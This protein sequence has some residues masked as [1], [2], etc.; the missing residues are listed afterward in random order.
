IGDAR[1]EAGRISLADWFAGRRYSVAGQ[2]LPAGL[3][4]LE[5][6]GEWIS[7]QNQL[8]RIDGRWNRHYAT[9]AFPIKANRLLPAVNVEHED[10]RQHIMGGDSLGFESFRFTRISPNIAWRSD[11]LE[12]SADLTFRTDEQWMDGALEHA[13]D[14]WTASSGIDYAGTR[15]SVDARVGLRRREF[16]E[17]FRKREGR[18]D[19][20]TLVVRSG[21]RWRPRR[22][23]I[24]VLASYEANS[25]R[26]PLLQEIFVRTGPE[27]GQF[28][29][30]DLN[31]DEVIQL[32]E[33]IPERTPNEGVYGRTYLPTDS[34]IS[35]VSVRARSELRVDGD[36]LWRDA[37]GWRRLLAH[38][39]TRSTF[40]VHESTRDDDLAR[41]YLLD[42]S[43]FR[44]PETTITGRARM[45]QSVSLWPRSRIF[46]I[47]AD[48]SRV[49]SLNNR[50]MGEEAQSFAVS[51][52][53]ARWKPASPVSLLLRVAKERSRQLSQQ[54]ETRRFDISSRRLEPEVV[55]RLGRQ[56][57][58][59]APTAFA[60]KNDSSTDQRAVIVRLPLEV[61]YEVPRRL[62]W[63]SRFEV[64]NVKM[65]GG[66]RGLAEFELTDGRG[67]GVSTLWTSTARYSINDYL[68]ARLQYDARSPYG[69]PVVH[70]LRM[71]LSA[72]F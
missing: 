13:Y 50:T 53:E 40:E 46:G 18:A 57:R 59:S 6:R 4:R 63:T 67:P 25:E 35:S 49:H 8:E 69:A 5:Y 66:S 71:Q 10:R 22:R 56:L 62:S 64:A 7:S 38:V 34:L 37:D 39:A 24:D 30:E 9:I 11:E 17:T 58:L 72:I 14:A 21:M 16:S 60:W 27:M 19:Q 55:L 47:D 26:T 48:H 12:A 52:A 65:T 36:A 23:G 1:F 32:D 15:L 20:T 2:A 33:M 28:V 70:T 41:I 31:G 68:S 45:A 43:R 29:W 51:S 3:P 42:L 44:N 61:R 54:F